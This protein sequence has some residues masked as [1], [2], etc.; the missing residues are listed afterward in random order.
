MEYNKVI[1]RWQGKEEEN[2]MVAELIIDLAAEAGCESFE[3]TEGK[4]EVIAFVQ[5]GQL[6]ESILKESIEH[7]Y[8]SSIKIVYE[9]EEVENK[10]WN[11]NW[12]KEGFVPIN[13]SNKCVIYDARHTNTSILPTNIPLQI[14]I[15]TQQ[16]FGTGTHETT[17]MIVEE[18]L[19]INIKNQRILDCGSGTGILGIVAA[20]LGAKE[21]VAYDI[22]EWSTKNTLHNA[23]LNN[24]ENIQVIQGNSAILHDIKQPFE[25]IVANINR[26]ILLE[27][28]PIFQSKMKDGAL[29]ILSG[30]YIED[31]ALLCQKAQMLGMKEIGRKELNK[32]A[33][34]ML[35]N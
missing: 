11:E 17:Q 21:I 22:D 35:G 26:N 16:A 20:K 2:P 28:M 9:I 27:D 4:R 7:F 29:L 19:N 8:I 33:C 23:Q 10:N 30:F 13:I 6:I 25:L 5:K 18:L 1:F 32:W 3:E 24:I 31:I 12:E 34:L 14:G 15:E